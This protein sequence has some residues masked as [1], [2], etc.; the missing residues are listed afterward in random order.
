MPVVTRP[1]LLCKLCVS[2]DVVRAVEGLSGKGFSSSAQQDVGNGWHCPLA[3]TLA[4][5]FLTSFSS[6]GVFTVLVFIP[7]V[8]ILLFML[9]GLVLYLNCVLENSKGKFCL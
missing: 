1:T 7:C 4:P 5:A 3:D 8:F 9:H 6:P 2:S